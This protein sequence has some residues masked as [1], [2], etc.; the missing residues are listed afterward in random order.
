MDRR[1]RREHFS[2]AA[3]SITDDLL[4]RNILLLRANALNRYAIVAAAGSSVNTLTRIEIV[5][6]GAPTWRRK[7][8]GISFCSATAIGI[9][10][11]RSP[12]ESVDQLDEDHSKQFQSSGGDFRLSV[13]SIRLCH[14][15]FVP[16]LITQKLS[17]VFFCHA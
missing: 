15:K 1:T 9:L 10:H 8:E 16:T 17:S 12:L 4:H 13:R 7:L 5:D 11:D 2:S 6:S 14:S 3:L